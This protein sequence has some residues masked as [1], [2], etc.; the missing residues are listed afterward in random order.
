MGAWIETSLLGGLLGGQLVA[1]H[2]GATIVV[3]VSAGAGGAA[4]RA[5][6]TTLLCPRLKPGVID[7]AHLRRALATHHGSHSTPTARC[8]TAHTRHSLS[9]TPHPT[10][11]ALDTHCS[12]S[13]L[14]TRRGALS[15]LT[16]RGATAHTWHSLNAASHLSLGALSSQRYRHSAID[17]HCLTRLT[18]G[19]LSILTERRTSPR[20]RRALFAHCL[21]CVFSGMVI[22]I[23]Q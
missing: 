22:F 1:P 14:T 13:A 4:Y 19:A 16:A 11:G 20:T 8:A 23:C 17:T 5:Q 9:A 15:S 6:L 3:G 2:V 7:T 10:L 12:L 18:L 21:T